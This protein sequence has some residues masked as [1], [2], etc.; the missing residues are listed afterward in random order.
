MADDEAFDVVLLKPRSRGTVRLRSADPAEPPLVELPNLRD[1]SDVERLGEGYRR[2]LEVASRPEVRR[3]C[4]DPLDGL[5]RRPQPP[6]A[7]L[8]EGHDA[9]RHGLDRA[10]LPVP[11]QVA[12]LDRHLVSTRDAAGE[13]DGARWEPFQ[14]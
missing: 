14:D 5:T 10:E 7:A 9:R 2:G 13:H 6:I 3:L 1:P 11:L 8:A 12:D 4:T